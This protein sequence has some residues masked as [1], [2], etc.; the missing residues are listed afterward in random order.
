MTLR[1][2]IT[3]L[4]LRVQVSTLSDNPSFEN[5]EL[6]ESIQL[7]EP[8]VPV[9]NLQ[10]LRAPTFKL[11]ALSDD[12][13]KSVPLDHC[14]VA[15]EDPHVG[16][17][18]CVGLKSPYCGWDLV[19]GSCVPLGSLERLTGVL[20]DLKNGVHDFCPEPTTLPGESVVEGLEKYD[21]MSL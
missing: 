7:F 1:E 8:H 17:S 12:E 4:T 11:V 16:C 10:I 14:S 5:A 9:R 20:Q 21:K 19:R 13:V 15:F 6:L 2:S 18:Q 3:K